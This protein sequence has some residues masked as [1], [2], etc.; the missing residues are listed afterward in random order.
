[1]SYLDEG[2]I[3]E[4]PIP[5]GHLKL[6]RL[7]MGM[8]QKQTAEIISV[9]CD[10]TLDDPYACEDLTKLSHPDYWKG[11]KRLTPDKIQ[12]SKNTRTWRNWE[13]GKCIMPAIIEKYI[14]AFCLK[15][16]GVELWDIHTLGPPPSQR[17][18]G[19]LTWDTDDTSLARACKQLTIDQFA[20]L[21]YTTP[22]MIRRYEK[23]TAQPGKAKIR[24]M[25]DML[26]D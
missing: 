15:N 8:T 13:S 12:Y 7:H 18:A 2:F 22:E 5:H 21:L 3:K 26:G 19:T 23:G 16:L 24:T 10:N 14:K 6:F 25:M 20:T 17:A 1:M 4:G 9:V 11:Y